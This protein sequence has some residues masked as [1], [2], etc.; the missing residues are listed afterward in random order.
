MG[1]CPDQRQG[2]YEAVEVLRECRAPPERPE[3]TP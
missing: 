2:E 3:Y 1:E